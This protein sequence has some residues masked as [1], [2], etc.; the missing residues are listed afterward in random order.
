MFALRGSSVLTQD[1]RGVPNGVSFRR[2]GPAQF[3]CI[4]QLTL[5]GPR[6][7]SGLKTFVMALAIADDLGAVLVI[8]LFYSDQ[9]F[10]IPMIGAGAFLAL[11]LASF[12]RRI[13]WVGVYAVLAIG[14]WVG[15]LVSGIHATIAGI[16]LPLVVPVR[17]RIQPKRFLAV[18][19]QRLDEFEAVRALSE[20]PTI[21]KSG[22]IE[23][24]EEL[25]QVTSEAIPVG[26]GFERLL[27]PATA[28][29]I[30]PLF[31]LFNAGVVLDAHFV[32]ALISPVGLGVL[33]GLI[34]GK[35]LGVL[36]ASWVIIRWRVADM[37][38]GIT[39]L[40]LV[41]AAILAGIGFTMAI[42][43][44]DL[45]LENDQ[46]LVSSKI[47]VLGASVVCAVG[48]CWVLHSSWTRP[49]E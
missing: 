48:G 14:V 8:A 13:R 39:W 25:H 37:A 15:I 42:F 4:K 2:A 36:A 5:L 32:Y 38:A 9:L 11:L 17:S 20:T 21:L 24:L 27:H 16:V 3:L 43:V 47:A 28:Y 33:L 22:E 40:Q 29:V 1:F 18:A 45:A 6:V 34:L 23:T 19:R 7:P 31:A 10:V 41:G 44:S 26:P 30:L 46:V 12:R 49:S 35:P